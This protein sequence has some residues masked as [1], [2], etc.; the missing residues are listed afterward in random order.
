MSWYPAMDTA[1]VMR[2]PEFRAADAGYR[3]AFPN[4]RER[5]P[6]DH[7]DSPDGSRLRRV[8]MSKV[9]ESVH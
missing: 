1:V 3:I 9:A 5:L 4:E 8:R 2:K 7:R 6:F